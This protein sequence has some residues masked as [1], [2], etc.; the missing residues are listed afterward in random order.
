[1]KK[2]KLLPIIAILMSAPFIDLAQSQKECYNTVSFCPPQK[3]MGFNRPPTIFFDS[4]QKNA[5]NV[6]G[7]TGYYDPES[8]QIVVS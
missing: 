5:E 3:K 8:D 6:L 4:D 7:K 2:F 1:M